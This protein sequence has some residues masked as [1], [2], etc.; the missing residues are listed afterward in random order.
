MPVMPKP[1]IQVERYKSQRQDIYNF[2]DD[3]EN[4]SRNDVNQSVN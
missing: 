3:V 1:E 2:T 4:G